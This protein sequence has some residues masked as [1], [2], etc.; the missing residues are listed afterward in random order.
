MRDV[1]PGLCLLILLLACSPAA[2]EPGPGAPEVTLRM[3]R[4]AVGNERELRVQ[5]E[6]VGVIRLNGNRWTLKLDSTFAS[7]ERSERPISPDKPY[8]REVVTEGRFQNGGHAVRQEYVLLAPAAPIRVEGLGLEVSTDEP[9]INQA[10]HRE[11]REWLRSQGLAA[12]TGDFEEIHLAE[13]GREL[14]VWYEI[15]GRRVNGSLVRGA[16][17][18]PEARFDSLFHTTEEGWKIH[19]QRIGENGRFRYHRKSLELVDTIL[20]VTREEEP[21]ELRSYHCGCYGYAIGSDWAT[22]GESHLYHVELEWLDHRVAAGFFVGWE[23][24]KIFPW[25]GIGDRARTRLLARRAKVYRLTD[26]RKKPFAEVGIHFSADPPRDSLGAASYEVRLSPP[27]GTLEPLARIEYAANELVVYLSIPR[28]TVGIASDDRLDWE[29]PLERLDALLAAMPTQVVRGDGV[30][31]S[32]LGEIETM[33]D[34][35]RLIREPS[36][37]NLADVVSEI[38][39]LTAVSKVHGLL[40]TDGARYSADEGELPLPPRRHA[41][42]PAT[43]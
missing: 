37:E 14:T 22:L 34:W 39:A 42:N 19:H 30:R 2:E 28:V 32:H 17:F 18:Q 20:D 15:S 31:D 25:I 27:D 40:E 35:I 13:A 43:R 11:L 12:D 10:E 33:L 21:R 6:R 26:A 3:T 8:P 36:E 4:N 41:V 1:R 9:G 24:R 29:T 7:I 5:G 38:D 16:A 23:R